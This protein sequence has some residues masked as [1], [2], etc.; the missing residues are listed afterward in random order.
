[1]ALPDRTE[2][3]ASPRPTVTVLRIIARL[4]VGGPAIHTALLTARLDD[5]GFR[6]LL[7][8]GTPGQHEGDMSY[9][10]R[11]L[12]VE[13]RVIPELGRDLSWRDDLVAFGKLVRLMRELRPQIV[14]THTA[15]AGAIGRLAALVAG[16]P[17]RVHTFH[18]HVFRG[19]FSPLKSQVFLWIERL[20]GRLTSCVV[21]ISERQRHDFCEVYRVV[22]PLRCVVIP[23]GFDLWPFTAE[24]PLGEMRRDLNCPAGWQ[25]VGIVGRLV[26]IKNHEMFLA[27]AR[28]VLDAHPGVGFV[29]VGDG[30]R[31]PTLESLARDLGISDHVFFL[32]WRRDLAAVY[33]DLDVVALTSI[34]EGTP[35]ALIEAMAAGRPVV[36]TAVGGVPD[37]VQNEKTGLLVA[38]G[39]AAGFS[40]AVLRLLADPAL[41]QRLATEGRDRVVA[42]YGSQRLV[43]DVRNLYLE[44]LRKKGMRA[45]EPTAAAGTAA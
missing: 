25:L 41:R 29:I 42:R 32:G 16:V 5:Q 19:Y 7:V 1:M 22:H 8:T 38:D 37:V 33:A 43:G 27:A 24:Q 12:G 45:P 21:A 6:S 2:A 13:P 28:R 10:A 35:V 30:E 20:L 17:I 36:S 14:H 9:L 11:Q 40:Q 39:D 3:G 15:K 18:G 26:P 4:N 34:S 31:R 44:L 23:L